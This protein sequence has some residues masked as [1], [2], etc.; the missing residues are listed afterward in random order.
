MITLVFTLISI[1]L[2][3][4]RK[5]QILDENLI[6]ENN[7][8]YFVNIF[9]K[10]VLVSSMVGPSLQL[11]NSI[12]F[13]KMHYFKSPFSSFTDINECDLSSDVC[14]NGDCT[15]T[16]G[17]YYCTCNEGFEGTGNDSCTGKK[18]GCPRYK[19]NI[20]FRIHCFT[21]ETKTR[22]S[23]PTPTIVGFHWI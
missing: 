5:P 11:G 13:I 22:T 9:N 6:K 17:S 2:T 18:W 15:N 1:S 21:D 23:K 3:L 8:I 14:R 16:D 19:K 12:I 20:M 7:K 10:Q 4:L